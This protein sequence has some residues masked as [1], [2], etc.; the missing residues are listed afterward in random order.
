MAQL[1]TSND[2]VPLFKS[3]H[4]QNF[5][6][7]IFTVNYWEDKNKENEAENLK[8]LREFDYFWN[9][10]HVVRVVSMQ[11]LIRYKVGSSKCLAMIFWMGQ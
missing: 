1:A 5:I 6:M 9:V 3:S 7:D 11:S 4:R 10:K 8:K 2:R